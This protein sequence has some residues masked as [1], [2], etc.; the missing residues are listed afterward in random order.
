MVCADSGGG[1]GSMND[2]AWYS[3]TDPVRALPID[4]E[5]PALVA[6]VRDHG[7]VVLEAPPGAGKTTRVPRALL[8]AGIAGEILVLEPRRLA[9]RLAANRVAEEL[10]E[11]VGGTVGYSVRFEEKKSER[12]RIRFLTEGVLTRRLFDDPTL[13]G[14]G[15][16]VLDEFHERHLQGDLALA[17]LDRALRTS[18]PDIGVVVM[19]ATLD[20]EPVAKYL[21]AVRIRS[22]GRAYPVE[23]TYETE[24][25]RPLELRVASAVRRALTIDPEGDVLVFLPGAREIRRAT[26]ACQKLVA[27]HG[28]DLVALHGDLS[29][30]EQNRAVS[31]GPRRKVVLS[32][33]VAESSITVPGV[34]TVVDSGL[35]RAATHSPFTGLPSLETKKV[36]RASA[37]QREGRAGRVRAGR[38][39]RLYSR[40]DFDARNESDLPEIQRA[41]MSD[42][43]LSL[44]VAKLPPPRYL[45][46]PKEAAVTAAEKL[47]VR[48]GALDG[49]LAATDLGRRMARFPLAPRLA[50]LCVAG[51]DL[52]IVDD[53]CGAAAL[54]SERDIRQGRG[55]FGE[56]A[57]DEPTCPSDVGLLLDKLRE[58]EGS[59]QKSQAARAM[60]LDPRAVSVV[61]TSRRELRRRCRQKG[62]APASPAA[63]EDALA[64]ALLLAFPDRFAKRQKAGAKRLAIGGGLVGTLSDESVVRDAP[65][66]VALDADESR[67][68]LVR[69]AQAVDPSHVLDLFVDEVVEERELTWN[70]GMARV[71]AR[72]RLVYDGVAFDESFDPK[73]SGADVT[74]RLVDEVLARGLDRLVPDGALDALFA[75]ARHAA[76][77]GFPVRVPDDTELRAIVESA[78]DGKRS[79]RELADVAFVDWIHGAIEGAELLAR[80]CP[81]S[82]LLPSGRRAKVVY[83][84]GKPPWVESYLQDFFGLAASPTIAGEPVVLHLL[85][86]NKRAVQITSDL[87]SF[88]KTHYP[89]LR[90]ELGR[91]YPKHAWPEDTTTA[92]PMR[93]PRRS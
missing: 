23:T 9:A 26:D 58:I 76:R 80:V 87:A 61:E 7:R 13:A 5:L 35:A 79:L 69:L 67:G 71:E 59:G 14:V 25:D 91:R 15:V 64:R 19:S 75:R 47:L 17:L 18:R 8:D 30:D 50:R 16:V 31:P 42:T 86:P 73:P 38:C 27:E 44:A 63:L 1:R 41:D 49:R 24:D 32:T 12:T 37:K 78:C 22:E 45:D 54:L 29:L 93:F 10:G 40:A 62:P 48:L 28:A 85:A 60:R 33:N 43:L 6:A 56:V 52:G 11:A 3:S 84:D 77:K 81:E 20:A 65:F 70:E 51:E 74:R 36:S 55:P 57:S 4:A 2:F 90:K 83:E 39:F 89:P 66:I 34:V 92:I 68:I 53:A 46:P 82:L 88:F 21:D 72:T